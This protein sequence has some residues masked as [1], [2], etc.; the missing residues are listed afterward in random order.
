MTSNI[1]TV[2]RVLRLVLGVILLVAPFVSN[3][4]IFASTTTVIISVILGI[5]MVATAA[6]RFCPLYRLLGIRTCPR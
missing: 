2:D 6:M 1:G 4:A 5:V 3:L